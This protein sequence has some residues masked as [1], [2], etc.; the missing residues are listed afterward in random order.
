MNDQDM[1]RLKE[2]Q[3][4]DWFKKKEWQKEIEKVKKWGWKVESD[5]L[6]S[7]GIEFM[8]ETYLPTVIK[9]ADFLD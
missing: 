6:V 4:Y 7:L 8:G 3:N 2:I 5:S 1:K 9:E